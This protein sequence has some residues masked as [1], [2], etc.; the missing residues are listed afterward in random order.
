MFEH[1]VKVWIQGGAWITGCQTTSHSPFCKEGQPAKG[2]GSPPFSLSLPDAT[3]W[4]PD[5][6]PL[7]G[8]LP[9]ALST[10]Q[11]GWRLRAQSQA[12]GDGASWVQHL[13]WPPLLDESTSWLW[14]PR[15]P[16]AD[17]GRMGL[18]EQ[19]QPPGTGLHMARRGNRQRLSVWKPTKGQVVW[20]PKWHYR[21]NIPV[22]MC[23]AY[24][25]RLR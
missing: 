13:Q 15:A 21:C 25:L 16:V 19:Q 1:L 3:S 17:H 11:S 9:H 18:D 6:P 10:L 5:L 4:R 23:D 8:G 14:H 2:A 7:T 24:F 20:I 22:W 12:N